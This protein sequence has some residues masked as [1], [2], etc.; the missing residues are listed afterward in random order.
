MPSLGRLLVGVVLQQLAQARERTM[1]RH[2]DRVRTE[3]EQLADLPRG[4]IGSVAEREQLAVADVEPLD[5]LLQGQPLHGLGF[6]VTGI[7]R[8]AGLSSATRC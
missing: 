1:E 7:G 6:D 5:R 3:L 4:E 2:L 8:L